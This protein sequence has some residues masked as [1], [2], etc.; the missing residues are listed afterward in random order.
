[1]GD[2]MQ[3]REDTILEFKNVTKRFPGVKALDGVTFSIRRGHVH[4]LM[5][6][7]GAGKST[8]LKIINGMYRPDEGEIIF[9]GKK[10]MPSGSAQARKQGISMIH[11]ELN[12]IP[13]MSI[14]QNMFLGKEITAKSHLLMDDKS[15]YDETKK[16][17]ESQGLGEYDPDTK[18]KA[19]TIAE[20]QMVEII[21]AV[22]CNAK[23]IL[24]DE[25]TS[26]L[27]EKEVEIL[28]DHIFKLRE[29]GIT[30]IYIS[31]KI[32]EIFQVADDISIFRDGQHIETGTIG[33]YTRDTIIEK[34]V[35]RKMSE[36]F[37][38]RKPR[39]GKVALR[40]ENLKKE[41]C[42]ENVSFE[43][44]E[45][46]I[47]GVSGLVG[48]GR[49]E[50]ARCIVGLDQLEGGEI[51]C[52]GKAVTIHTVNDA[53]KEKI[54]LIP[55]DRKKDGLVL[56]RSIKENISLV[57][58]KHIFKSHFVKQKAEKNMVLDLVKKLAIKAPGAETVAGTLSGGN[59]QKV[60][61]AK[62]LSV[63]P[64]ILIMDEPTRG[65][66][67]S[68]KYEIYKLMN[69]MTDKGVAIILI[70]SDME[71]LLGMSD[72]VIVVSHGKISGE[73]AGEEIKAEAVMH[74][75]VEGGSKE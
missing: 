21:K 51:Y 8:L 9:D 60:V 27:S 33:D 22:S 5:G 74:L 3:G 61:L 46:E 2:I 12:I 56:L 39:P 45:G 13:E 62:W 36:V 18:M 25:P 52:F 72:R 7:N 37:P 31:H 47:L 16:L 41:G 23:V 11:Q 29:R 57:A 53:I 55:E 35:G 15:M 10:W 66:D 26:S 24:M 50:I 38:V 73:L 14:T 4:C 67:V 17:L 44:R 32:D 34:M 71:E 42:F 48:A 43:V 70:D 1:M 58:L 65:I 6:E 30:I 68:T 64:K 59:Q 75:A 20:A 63:S 40:V 54:V 28:F 19:L 49:T 69:Q